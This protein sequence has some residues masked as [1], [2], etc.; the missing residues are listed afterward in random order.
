M[1]ATVSQSRGDGRLD[2]GLE[3][4]RRPPTIRRFAA[5]V[6]SELAGVTARRARGLQA[7]LEVGRSDDPLE[8]EA[9]RVAERLTAAPPG[10][11]QRACACGGS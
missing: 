7:R 5:P 11:L 6:G 10:R 8:H 1:L 2:T 4:G 9:D 3:R